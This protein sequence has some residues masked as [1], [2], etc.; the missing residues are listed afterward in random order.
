MARGGKTGSGRVQRRGAQLNFGDE[1]IR[2]T[3]SVAEKGPQPDA[4]YARLSKGDFR[5]PW[6][7]KPLPLK[8]PGRS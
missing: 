7:G 5:A 6:D 1:N 8:P 4:Y 3:P 2:R